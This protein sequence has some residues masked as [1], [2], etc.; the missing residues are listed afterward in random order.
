[1][2]TSP[3]EVSLIRVALSLDFW[4]YP[5]N[6]AVISA[7]RFSSALAKRDFEFSILCAE[8]GEAPVAEVR[9]IR[10]PILSL[11]GYNGVITRM[12]SPLARPV[13]SAV[14]R[15]LENV[16]ILHCQLTSALG[17]TAMQ[18]ARRL[19]IPVVWTLHIQAENVLW[20]MGFVSRTLSQSI[21]YV[22]RAVQGLAIQELFNRADLVIAPTSFAARIAC[23]DG[24]TAPVRVISN[25]VPNQFFVEPVQRGGENG[26]AFCASGALAGRRDTRS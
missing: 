20:N 7:R 21:R 26:S 24:L 2:V 17:V 5:Y 1:M 15:A 10:F 25:G 11:P 19:G 3:K 16:D 13:R 9:T 4:E 6:G 8:G 14:R 18:E 23:R 12:K 22:A